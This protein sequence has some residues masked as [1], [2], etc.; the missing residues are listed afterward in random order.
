MKT[1]KEPILGIVIESNPFVVR[2]PSR[3]RCI[4]FRFLTAYFQEGDLYDDIVGSD[5]D[6]KNGAQIIGVI[7]APAE[8]YLLFDEDSED[9]N[10]IAAFWGGVPIGTES[11]VVF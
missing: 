9:G 4:S 1:Y 5:I 7:P 3:E 10:A 11:K 2:N 8:S 6:L